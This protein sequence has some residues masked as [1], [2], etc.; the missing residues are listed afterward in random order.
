MR[1][2]DDGPR[3]EIFRS[4]FNVLMCKFD[5]CYIRAVVGKIIECLSK[6]DNNI[7]FGKTY[8]NLRNKSPNFLEAF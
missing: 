1:L 8:I 3:T 5:I 6:G 7:L 2:P 4:V